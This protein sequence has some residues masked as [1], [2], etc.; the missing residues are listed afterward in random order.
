MG[1][2]KNFLL[3]YGTIILAVLFAAALAPLLAVAF[4]DYPLGDD[5]SYGRYVH[6]ALAAGGSLPAVLC[7]AFR[8]V[9]HTYMTWQGTYSAVFLMSIQPGVFAEKA[10][11]V[12]PFIMLGLLICS[13]LVLLNTVLCGCLH[14][15]RRT[16]ALLGIP[17]LFLAV[18]YPPSLAQGFYWYNGA[19]YYTFFYSVMLLYFSAFIRFVKNGEKGRETPR[20]VLLLL[21]AA[22]LGGA[23]FVTVLIAILAG[24]L[25]LLWCILRQRRRLLQSV[26]VQCA[27]L[28]GFAVSALAP[29]NAVRQAHFFRIG[30]PLTIV[31]SIGQSAFYLYRWTTAVAVLVFILISPLLYAMAG[32]SSLRFQ[33]PGWFLAFTLLLFAAQS[34][35]P[36]YAMCSP[37]ETRLQDI[38]YYSYLWLV[39]VNLFYFFGW[40]QK[41]SRRLR[42]ALK[43]LKARL[44]LREGGPARYVALAA[45]CVLLAALTGPAGAE[46]SGTG[47][48]ARDLLSGDAQ[49]YA[50]QMDARLKI[51]NDAGVST[52]RV[53]E[54]TAHP[55]SVYLG[56][57]TGNPNST[58]NLDVKTYYHK[59]SVAAVGSGRRK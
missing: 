21:L 48:C 16:V 35:P 40:Y 29:G 41:R 19:V 11:A 3:R 38:I 32:R 43:K 15:K 56:D 7:A 26:A 23:N 34:A 17:V 33:M 12:V 18:E 52:V 57:I 14:E 13:T 59:K 30:V 49:A 8:T 58:L 9:A 44:R 53:P 1:K 54:L 39:P 2:I 10:Y 45:A 42:E 50:A 20:F 24:F 31:F 51:Y 46:S 37:G 25:F 36:F 22:V 55:R 5:L 27:L 6:D 28:A 47:I 4:C